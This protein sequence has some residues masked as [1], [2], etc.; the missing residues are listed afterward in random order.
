MHVK[1]GND[2]III[3]SDNVYTYYNLDH[4]ISAPKDETFDTNAYV[5]SMI[6]MKTLVSNIK[7]IIPG[8]DAL[9]FSRFPTVAEGI[10][11]IR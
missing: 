1:T 6:K 2:K 5:K 11:K 3:A 4:L 7:Y 9:L 8:H 10:I